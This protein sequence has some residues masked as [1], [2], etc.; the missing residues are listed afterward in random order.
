[1]FEE[2]DDFFGK[3]LNKLIS[4]FQLKN[5]LRFN[6][7]EIEEIELK[8]LTSKEH[9]N[10]KE[11]I[12][13]AWVKLALVVTP[14][15]DYVQKENKI[16]DRIVK[17]LLVPSE[18]RHFVDEKSEAVYILPIT[19][20]HNAKEYILILDFRYFSTDRLKCRKG[21]SNL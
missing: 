10:I 9:K 7:K 8:K 4:I 16:Y 2:A 20:I 15:C 14:V 1:M 19:I 12:K 17:G 3:L 11:E 5:Y 21:N 18:Y 13:K 6:N